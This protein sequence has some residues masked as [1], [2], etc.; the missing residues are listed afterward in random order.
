MHTPSGGSVQEV[1]PQAQ[2]GDGYTHGYSKGLYP[3]DSAQRLRNMVLCPDDEQP[4]SSE[5]RL[6][7]GKEGSVP[8]RSIRRTLQWKR[9]GGA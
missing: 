8:V 2:D 7:L 6:P 5:R 3:M 9:M 1:A 4:I